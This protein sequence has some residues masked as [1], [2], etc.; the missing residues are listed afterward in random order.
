MEQQVQ[1]PPPALPP[2][3]RTTFGLYSPSATHTRPASCAEA[4]CE[5]HLKGWAITV[6]AGSPDETLVRQTA[7]GDVDGRGRRRYYPPTPNGPGMVRYVFPAGQPCFR[8]TTHRVPLSRP[9]IHVIR[10]GDHRAV[11]GEPRYVGGEQWINTFGEHQDRLA[12]AVNGAP[13]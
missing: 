4:G 10:G 3:A 11:I 9:A 5:H 8:A 6:M 1:Y 13:Q 12:R 2:Q 7:A